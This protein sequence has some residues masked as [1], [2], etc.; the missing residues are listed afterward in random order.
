MPGAFWVPLPEILHAR[1]CGLSHKM[2]LAREEGLVALPH[3]GVTP[4]DFYN[5]VRT[6]CSIYSLMGKWCFI[7]HIPLALRQ[8]RWGCPALCAHSQLS[9]RGIRSAA[10]S[11]LEADLGK[12]PAPG[13]AQLTTSCSSKG[14]RADA[15]CNQCNPVWS[16]ALEEDV[17]AGCPSWGG[18]SAEFLLR[19]PGTGADAIPEVLLPSV[20]GCQWGCKLK[21]SLPEKFPQG[22]APNGKPPGS[23]W[24]SPFFPLP[25]SQVSE[26]RLTRQA[27]VMGRP[28]GSL[29]PLSQPAGP[30]PAAV[31][32]KSR[33]LLF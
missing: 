12:R 27:G 10:E 15:H 30:M 18:R 33:S 28:T 9:Q 32:T 4:G 2:R 13:A 6:H 1:S 31:G 24:G 29:L 7:C 25:I 3:W 8:G 14:I 19:S 17:G 22:P 23:T 5:V 26:E 21:S 11:V 16:S 20:L